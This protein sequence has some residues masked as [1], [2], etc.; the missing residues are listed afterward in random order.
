[1]L[2][3]W[4]TALHQCEPPAAHGLCT[5]DEQGMYTRIFRS[6]CRIVVLAENVVAESVSQ[7]CLA[8]V[9]LLLPHSK[10]K[11]FVQKTSNKTNLNKTPQQ[12]PRASIPFPLFLKGNLCNLYLGWDLFQQKLSFVFTPLIRR[13]RKLL[14]VVHNASSFFPSLFQMCLDLLRYRRLWEM[15]CC[16]LAKINHKQWWS[17]NVF[18]KVS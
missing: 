11:L 10:I 5:G 3:H 15:W 8:G 14:P 2:Y 7:S 16:G 13:G 9:P 6:A 12:F 1:M 4:P 17:N 18:N